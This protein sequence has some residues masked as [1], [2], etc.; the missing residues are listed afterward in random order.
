MAVHSVRGRFA[1]RMAKRRACS[2]SDGFTLLEILVTLSIVAL[3]TGMTTAFLGQLRKVSQIHHDHETQQQLDQ[4]A[5]YLERSIE[6]AMA[7][8]LD[9]SQNQN[10]VFFAGNPTQLSFLAGS[11]IG[12]SEAALRTRQIRFSPGLGAGK[13]VQIMAVRRF[14]SDERSE[15]QP[16]SVTILEHASDLR[17]EYFGRLAGQSSAVWTDSWTQ[18]RSL[19]MAVRFSVNVERNGKSYQSTGIAKIRAAQN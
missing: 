12:I 17:F 9:I 16:I 3:I 15:Q 8:P 19:P 4:T 1:S 5:R 7:L 2:S 13:I 10:R 18:D 11:R 6:A 14:Q